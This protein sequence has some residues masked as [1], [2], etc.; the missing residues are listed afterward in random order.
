MSSE[1]L[2]RGEHSNSDFPPKMELYI[3]EPSVGRWRESRWRA[4]T[5][6][7]IVNDMYVDSRTSAYNA[8]YLFNPPNKG[9]SG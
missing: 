7:L 1:C 9:V 3:E 2:V 5:A 6:M 8:K 4:D